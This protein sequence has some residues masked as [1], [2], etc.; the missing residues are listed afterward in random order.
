MNQAERQTI[1]DGLH[2][3]MALVKAEPISETA[4]DLLQVAAILAQ[5]IVESG[6][7]DPAEELRTTLESSWQARLNAKFK[8]D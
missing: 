7:D 5:T 1:V 3:A 2:R 4:K 8:A 6:S